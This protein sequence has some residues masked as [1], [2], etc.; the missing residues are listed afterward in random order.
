MMSKNV[1]TEIK[2]KRTP[3]TIIGL[4]IALLMGFCLVALLAAYLT[5]VTIRDFVASWSITNLPGVTVHDATPVPD[6]ENGTP[7]VN[8]SSPL[9]PIG[10]PTPPPWDGANRVSMLVMGLDYRDWQAGEGPPRTDTMILFTV[11]PVN[12]TAGILS[13]PRD[14]WVNIPGYDYGRINSAYSLG[15]AY[16]LPG[17]GPQL[18]AAAVEELLGIKIDYYA[19][20]DFGAFARFIDEIGGVEVDVT[21]E[22]KLDPLGDGNTKKL[23]PGHYALPGNLALAYVR[24]RKSEGGDFDRSQRQQQV[25]MGI[26][27]RILEYDMLP[28]LISKAPTLYN[29]ISSGVHTNLGLD[30]AIR[31][32]WLAVQIPE[33]N[34]KRGAIGAG[35]VAFAQSPDGAQQVLKPLT[36][37]IRALR[38]EIFSETA[39]ASPLAT[40]MDLTQLVKEESARVTVMN[41]SSVSGLAA[42]T[43]DYLKS[44]GINVVETGNANQA[45]PS[46]LVT[47]YNGKPYTLKYLVD[48]MRINKFHIRYANDPA[49]P[50]DIVITLGDDWAQTNT[51]P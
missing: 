10:G 34:I 23:K 20:V 27:S 21:E 9:Q 26:R 19:Q 3:G 2:T 25:I 6:S 32:A 40:S 30:Q 48:L 44:Q 42:R 51:L 1:G 31:L 45:S 24:F 39:A 47:F 7:V 37:K 49:V 35:Q 33:E 18:A 12:R 41:A 36:E 16:K 46:T 22:L 11:D 28:M 43:V 15:E 17:G 14:L 5:F 38:D 4:R 13:I 50:A 8:M 29:E